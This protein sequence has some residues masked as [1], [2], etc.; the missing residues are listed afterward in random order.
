MDDEKTPSIGLVMPF[1]REHS[2]EP[3]LNRLVK[4]CPTPRAA[5]KSGY[6]S[7]FGES[8]LNRFSRLLSS[9][10]HNPALAANANR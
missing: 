4:T 10:R 2:D 7:I 6:G 5:D 8:E 3:R 1:G 9:S